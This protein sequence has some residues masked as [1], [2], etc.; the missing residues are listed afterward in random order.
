MRLTEKRRSRFE[1]VVKMRVVVKEWQAISACDPPQSLRRRSLAGTLAVFL[2]LVAT[3]ACVLLADRPKGFELEQMHS[4]EDNYAALLLSKNSDKYSRMVLSQNIL[5]IFSKSN[6]LASDKAAAS[7]LDANPK[8][9]HLKRQVAESQLAMKKA[10]AAEMLSKLKLKSDLISI[11]R[12]HHESSDAIASAI[13]TEKASDANLV[14]LARNSGIPVPS[15]SK[16]D[17]NFLKIMA[18]LSDLDSNSPEIRD[19]TMSAS[20]SVKSNSDSD[21]FSQKFQPSTDNSASAYAPAVPRSDSDA[22]ESLSKSERDVSGAPRALSFQSPNGVVS[23]NSFATDNS[24][25]EE[26]AV[27]SELLFNLQG[28]QNNLM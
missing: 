14:R 12:Q 20:L 22:M 24:T 3:A 10:A 6:K 18:G 2:V 11:S 13:Q 5:K 25:E 7:A 19:A 23:S 21:S 1:N 26:A 4:D 15:P 8:F 9:Q 27:S 17:S 28:L 16:P